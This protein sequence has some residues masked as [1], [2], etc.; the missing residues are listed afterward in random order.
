MTPQELASNLNNVPDA[1]LAQLPHAL[2]YA[3][4]DY[5]TPDQ[6]GR[7]SG[8]E[9][10][11]FARESV[12]D[13]PLMALPIAAAI[14]AYQLYKLFNQARSQP[15]LSQLGQGLSGIGEGLAGPLSK[16]FH[17]TGTGTGT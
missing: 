11:A 15:S 2:L 8:F 6:Q 14:P 1:T 17:T 9:H 5:I 3:A 12:A 13:N 7:L 10:R 16:V 4:R